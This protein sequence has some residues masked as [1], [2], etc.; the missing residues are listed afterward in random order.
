MKKEFDESEKFTDNEQQT[1]LDS[2]KF[3]EKSL[4]VFDSNY[5]QMIDCGDSCLL[6]KIKSY[7]TSPLVTDFDCIPDEVMISRRNFV[8]PKQAI[9]A[10]T[11]VM[12]EDSDFWKSFSEDIDISTKNEID[13]CFGFSIECAVK[14]PRSK[15]VRTK[16]QLTIFKFGSLSRKSRFIPSLR[17]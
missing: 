9:T 17:V 8:I 6:V 3:G 1:R 16:K 11:V 2:I 7:K 5:Y 10:L 14:D 12:G 13:Y 15:D 4:L